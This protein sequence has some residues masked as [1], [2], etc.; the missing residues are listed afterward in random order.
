MQRVA[1]VGSPGAGKTTF[2]RQLAERTGLPLVHL[3][4]QFWRPGWVETPRDEWIDR[5]SELVAAPRWIIEG[6]YSRTFDLRFARADTLLVLRAPRL[7]CVTRILGRVMREWH[8]ETQAPG[9]PEHFDLDFLRLVWNFPR[10]SVPRLDEALSR[11]PSSLVV[12]HLA[13]A[14]Q[15]SRYLDSLPDAPRS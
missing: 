8:L 4:E 15:K 7:V 12:V 2:S 6:N 9:C 14:A 1:I 13:G 10:Q 11:A 5:Q 3:D